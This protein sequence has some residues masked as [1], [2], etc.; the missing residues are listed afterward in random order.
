MAHNFT[1]NIQDGDYQS[2]RN[3]SVACKHKK[4]YVGYPNFRIS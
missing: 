4:H 1:K 2:P 3:G